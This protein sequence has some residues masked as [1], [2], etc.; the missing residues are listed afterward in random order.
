MCS[1]PQKCRL[2][3]C[4]LRKLLAKRIIISCS[5]NEF[6]GI[7]IEQAQVNFTFSN[8]CSIMA[9][10]GVRR[11]LRGLRFRSVLLFRLVGGGN[12]TAGE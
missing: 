6:L 3:A 2:I 5:G 11:L 9:C 10:Y 1:V 4:V 7:V 12:D 8:K